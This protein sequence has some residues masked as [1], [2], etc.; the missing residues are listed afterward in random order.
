MAD[1][2]EDVAV[3]FSAN[4]LFELFKKTCDGIGVATS[5]FS[6]KVRERDLIGGAAQKYVDRL[7]KRYSHVRILGMER[8]I[9]LRQI[10]VN[11]NILEKIRERQRISIDLLE[12]HFDRD[13]RSFGIKRKTKSGLQA[14]NSYDRFIVLGKPGAGKTTFLKHLIFE[15]IDGNSRK[16]RIPIFVPLKDYSESR[17]S[18]IDYAAKQFDICGFP[19]V[20][21]FLDRALTTGKCQ[22]LLDGLDEVSADNLDRVIREI[23]DL[24]DKF[25]NNQIIISCRVAAYNHWFEKFTDIEISDFSSKQIQQF[26]YNWFQDEPKIASECWVELSTDKSIRELAGIPLLLTLLCLAFDETMSFPQNRAELYKEALDALLKKWDSSRRIRR[27]VVYKHLSLKRK[28]SMFS[29]IAAETFENGQYFIPKRSLETRIARFV[30]NLPGIDQSKL[31]VDSEGIL[32]AIEAHHGILVQRAKGIYSFSHLTFQE[33]YTAQYIV[34]HIGEGSIA[35]LATRMAEEQWREVFLLT[36]GMLD[37]ADILFE[38]MAD[39]IKNQVRKSSLDGFFSSIETAIGNRKRP[40][41]R[42]FDRC[43]AVINSFSRADRNEPETRLLIDNSFALLRAVER[44]FPLELNPKKVSQKARAEIG[45]LRR[46]LKRA[47][48][49]PHQLHYGK[50]LSHKIEPSEL[51]TYLKLNRLLLDCLGTECYVSR[52]M[53]NRIAESPFEA[54]GRPNKEKASRRPRKKGKRK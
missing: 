33:Y 6:N 52:E 37:C 47:R 39:V 34:D 2:F 44:E 23:N 3:R 22:V 46:V 4:V 42:V 30:S 38:Q 28:E 54:V 8:P 20:E 25:E 11:V 45:E 31:D 1:P 5:W 9:S 36:S 24:G 15:S 7:E 19:D 53:R 32:R 27:S 17:Y 16:K 26:I 29:R 21:P 40:F 41:P 50:M 51:I 48:N 18:L 49:K 10:F 43:I 35:R 12:K 14:V 13:Q